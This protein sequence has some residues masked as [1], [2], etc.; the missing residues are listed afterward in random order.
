MSQQ[1]SRTFTIENE[2]GMHARPAGLLV[3]TL[4]QFDVKATV[5]KDGMAVNAKSILEFIMLAA[6]KGSALKVEIEGDRAEDAMLEV[7]KLFEAKFNEP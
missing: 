6:E 4:G 5:E 1:I 2:M 3:R 7:A